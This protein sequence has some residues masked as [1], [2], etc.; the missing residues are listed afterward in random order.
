MSPDSREADA[1]AVDGGAVAPGQFVVFYD[2]AGERC[3][4]GG[5]IDTLIPANAQ[6]EARSAL[7]DC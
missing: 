7:S 2:D 5:V 4:G 3:L 6:C 1:M